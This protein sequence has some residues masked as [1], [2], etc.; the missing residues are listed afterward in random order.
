ML[1]S[2]ALE[3]EAG[4]NPHPLRK[5]HTEEVLAR[6]AQ[7]IRVNP[8][9]EQR[10][11]AFNQAGL[12]PLDALHLASAV[13]ASADYFCTCDDQLLRRARS[14]HTGSPKVVT[15]VELIGEIGS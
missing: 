10:A 7:V 11:Q 13:Q 9:I 4:R 2:D 5:A 12:K 6:A 1:S 3:Y 14:L 8:E 15:P